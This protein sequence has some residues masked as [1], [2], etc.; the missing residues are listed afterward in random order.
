MKWLID[1]MERGWVPDTFIRMGIRSL[2]RMRLRIHDKGDPGDNLQAKMDF[3]KHLRQSP[4]ACRT[5]KAN[6]QH[7][8]LPPAFFENVLGPNLKYSCCYWPKDIET[9]AGAEKAALEQICSR[10]Q[11]EDGMEI[12]DLGCGWGAFGLWAASRYPGS[13]VV[14]VSNSSVQREFIQRK[15]QENALDNIEVIT[16]DANVFRSDR[17]FDRIVSIEMFEHM[18]NYQEL[19]ARI[20]T[21]LK[22]EG[23]LF[24]HIF[25]HRQ[26]A[27]FFE[28]EGQDNW[29][30]RYFFTG[31]MMP[32]DDLLLY[33]QNRLILSDHWRLNG[34]HYQ[35]TAEAWLK[36]MTVNREKILQV[37]EKVY[38]AGRKMKWFQRWRIFFMACSELWGFKK[39]NEWY[40]SHYLFEKRHD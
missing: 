15:A 40:V 28:T 4:V 2:D 7:Y 21:W 29:M 12:L 26:F 17:C 32:S 9:L 1:I 5:D 38:G 3:I 24:I 37:I 31:G 35:K 20:A 39:G 23:K 19:L 11:I 36:N 34:T 13:R 14:A 10:A 25:T 27:Y 18:R 33:F 16:S 22:P 30:G 6:E 8:E